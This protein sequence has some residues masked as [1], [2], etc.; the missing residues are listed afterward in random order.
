[1]FLFL[2][3]YSLRL[4]FGGFVLPSELVSILLLVIVSSG[5]WLARWGENSR[6]SNFDKNSVT[7]TKTVLMSSKSRLLIFAMMGK[8]FEN[9]F[10]K[11]LRILSSLVRRILTLRNI[12][13]IR[14]MLPISENI[15]TSSKSLRMLLLLLLNALKII[16]LR[17][18]LCPMF[19][20][21]MGRIIVL[22]TI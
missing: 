1:M 12:L 6:A 10:L 17:W 22:A 19:A 15:P 8:I 2:I 13:I 3:L 16:V 18:W 14:L 7:L 9:I 11:I 21:K 5:V 20:R 4:W